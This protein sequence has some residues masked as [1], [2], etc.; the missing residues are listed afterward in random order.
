MTKLTRVII[1]ILIVCI[2]FSVI[3]VFTMKANIVTCI[4]GLA[5]VI[6]LVVIIV[7]NKKAG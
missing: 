3:Q 5:S 2:V 4:L 6:S 7:K 1:A